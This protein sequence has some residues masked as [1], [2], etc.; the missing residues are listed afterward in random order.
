MVASSAV[1]RVCLTRPPCAMAVRV[2]FFL[3]SLRYR[4]PTLSFVGW[5]LTA[6]SCFDGDSSCES[7]RR[8]S[9]QLHEQPIQ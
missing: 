9:S 5:E 1:F 2:C 7:R 8:S 4:Q 6:S 3:S